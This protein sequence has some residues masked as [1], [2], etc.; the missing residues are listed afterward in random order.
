MIIVAEANL[1]G[2]VDSF[3]LI[4]VDNTVYSLSLS[5]GSPKSDGSTCLLS[6]NRFTWTVPGGTT[7]YLAKGV[8]V[9]TSAPAAPEDDYSVPASGQFGLWE[10]Q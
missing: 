1:F 8:R 9:M 6:N 4:G 5:D 2:C 3:K 7:S 10:G